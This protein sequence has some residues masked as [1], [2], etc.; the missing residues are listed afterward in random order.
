MGVLSGLASPVLAAPSHPGD[1]SMVHLTLRVHVPANTP[2]SATV[3][4]VGDFQGWIHDDPAYQLHRDPDGLHR[5]DLEFEAGA[6]LSF[7]FHRGDAASEE[8]RPD[9]SPVAARRLRLDRSLALDLTVAAWRDDA[10]PARTLAGDVTEH[11]DPEVL[12]GRRL[13]V[14]LPPGYHEHDATYPLLLMLDGQ[15]VFDRTTS[16][17]GEWEA[18]ETCE[19]LIAAGRIEPLVIVAVDNGRERRMEEYTPWPDPVRGGGGGEAH[20]RRLV[21][22]VLPWVRARY[23]VQ[24]DPAH[25][26]FAGSSLGGLM[27]LHVVATRA[28][29]FGKI[30]ALSPSIPWAGERVLEELRA[31]A[32]A[33]QQRLWVDMGTAEYGQ[34][35]DADG[36]GV[37][38]LIGS[39]RRAT[40]LLREAGWTPERLVVFEDEG[41]RHHES[42]WAARF[43]RVLE[44]LFPAQP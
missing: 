28:S 6:I 18:D 15:N 12:E 35:R 11:S 34:L 41:A 26:G 8:A 9:G 39:L 17:A 4:I 44:F 16:F 2:P 21:D 10:S 29:V 22:E 7:R 40:A 19:A 13:W 33:P 14:Y 20:L 23:R 1:S 27:G 25:V 3:G 38:D 31:L 36:D 43:G 32:P 24:V 37:D 30:A 42:A 5:I